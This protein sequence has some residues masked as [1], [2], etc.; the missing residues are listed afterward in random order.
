MSDRVPEFV[1]VLVERRG[2]EAGRKRGGAD[3]PVVLT[4]RT[5]AG[6]RWECRTAPLEGSDPPGGPFTRFRCPDVRSSE[7]HLLVIAREQPDDVSFSGSQGSG[8]MADVVAAGITW[9]AGAF[10]RRTRPEPPPTPTPPASVGPLGRAWR[11]IDPL[12]LIDAPTVALLRSHPGR[13]GDIGIT[14]HLN[15]HGLE[16][17][18]G[19]WDDSLRLEHVIDVGIV[20]ADRL[21]SA[22]APSR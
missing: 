4:G 16:L 22:G 7:H 9:A 14:A 12:G 5:P 8:A 6:S 11:V 3:E 18:S 17:G 15:Q 21:R 10:R 2:W 13:D 19:D 20:L 1:A